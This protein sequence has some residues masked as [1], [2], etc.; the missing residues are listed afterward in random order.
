LRANK[1][2]EAIASL[3]Y[4]NEHHK[5][6]MKTV[7]AN[8]SFRVYYDDIE[9]KKDKF[10]PAKVEEITSAITAIF[11]G[12]D[13][14]SYFVANTKDADC[15]NLENLRYYLTGLK[16]FFNESLT[17]EDYKEVFSVLSK[18]STDEDIKKAVLKHLHSAQKIVK[19]APDE[20]KGELVEA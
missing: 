5:S 13:T 19:R 7:F 16:S 18:A 17:R 4:L 6:D 12:L 11:G 2:T 9:P 20:F 10:K 14:K 8:V 15:E 3:N 1:Y